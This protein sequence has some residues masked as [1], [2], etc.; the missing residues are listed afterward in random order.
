MKT[1][2]ITMMTAIGFT[3]S[4]TY[5]VQ[6]VVQITRHGFKTWLEAGFNQLANLAEEIEDTVEYEVS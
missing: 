3:S 1:V 5:I 4:C 2:E 6:A